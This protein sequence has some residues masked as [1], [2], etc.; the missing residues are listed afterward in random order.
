MTLVPTPR[1][2][3]LGRRLCTALLIA[4]ISVAGSFLPRTVLA[5]PTCGNVIVANTSLTTDLVNCPMDGIVFGASNIILDCQGHHVTALSY[6]FQYLS[7][8]FRIQNVNNS[9]IKNCIEHGFDYGV[10][11]QGQVSNTKIVNNT[12]DSNLYSAVI[13]E[14]TF[15]QK[16]TIVSNFMTNNAAGLNFTS[17]GDLIYNNLFNN[18][19]EYYA[20]SHGRMNITKT[21]GK[22]IIG[23]PFLGGNFWVGYSGADTNC[24]GL[25][26][27]QTPFAGDNL[28]LASSNQRFGS[29]HLDNCFL[30]DWADY[31]NT[32]SIDITDLSIL[33]SSFGT[34]NTYWD[35]YGSGRVNIQDLVTVASQFGI[36]FGNAPFL[37]KGTTPGQMDMSWKNQCP[38]LSNPALQ[39]YCV[40]TLQ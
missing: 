38:S 9:T 39:A 23:G 40:A 28:P 25:G 17:S 21:P 4:I 20:Q 37:G 2:I 3:R 33:A 27:T 30:F 10:W 15:I 16:N 24:D 29:V 19:Y 36:S 34:S 8:G 14:P 22:N 7:A 5:A 31:F 6:N 26:D 32:G 13:G 1:P 18:S 11:I 12:L 35:L